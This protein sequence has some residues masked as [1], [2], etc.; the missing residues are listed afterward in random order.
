MTDLVVIYGSDEAVVREEE[1]DAAKDQRYV[2]ASAVVKGWEDA[3]SRVVS[4]SGQRRGQ[5]RRQ[6]LDSRGFSFQLA[7]TPRQILVH[8]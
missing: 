4:S 1:S 6:D 2:D 7:V 5:G 8:T 3:T